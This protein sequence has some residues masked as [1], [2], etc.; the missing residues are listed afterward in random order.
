[1]PLTVHYR[2]KTRFELSEVGHTIIADQPREDGGD[3]TGMSPV[4]LF[5]GSL[6]ACVAYFVTRYCT[7]HGLPTEGFRIDVDWGMAEQPHRVGTISLRLHVPVEI[8][9]GHRERLLKVAHGC[10][11]HQSLM[12]PPKVDI[13]IAAATNS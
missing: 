8:T 9:D 5:V 10:T 2:G 13:T 4:T 12:V 3:D 11:V 6:A 7:R 1:M